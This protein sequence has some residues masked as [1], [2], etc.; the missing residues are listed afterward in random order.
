MRSALLAAAALG[1][2]AA[3]APAAALA[4]AAPAVQAAVQVT[5][6]EL[7]QFAQAMEGVGAVGAQV[8]NNTPTAEQQ[9]AMAQAITASGLTIDRF[10][11][12][13]QAVSADQDLRAR[14]AIAATPESPA[15]SV[16]AGVTDAEVSQF[17]SAMGAVRAVAE[18]VE[19]G[20][21]T[22]EQQQAMAEAITASGLTIDRFNAI[23]GALQGDPRL[24]ARVAIA[25]AERQG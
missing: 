21:P 1:L 6:A 25:Q 15:G 9:A 16:G 19:N 3:A 8:Q 7:A 12:I 10:N 2:S 18:G 24:R 4:P 5:D 23:S 17:A 13:S 14:L 20:T 22:A 11:E